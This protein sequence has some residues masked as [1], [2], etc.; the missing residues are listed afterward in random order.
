[1]R[2]LSRGEKA[3]IVPWQSGPNRR[4]QGVE[5]VHDLTRGSLIE[6]RHSGNL[7]PYS[8]HLFDSHPAAAQLRH[9]A[10]NARL[11]FEGL[12]HPQ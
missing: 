8:Q 9:N 3:F 6:E 5:V 2:F 11:V 4:R 1:M 12:W 10:R 7:R